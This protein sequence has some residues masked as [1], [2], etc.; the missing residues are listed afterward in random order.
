MDG[1]DVGDRTPVTLHTL[2]SKWLRT[3]FLPLSIALLVC[4][5]SIVPLP[6]YIE[7]PGLAVGISRCV[8]IA[9]RPDAGVDGD[10]LLTTVSQRDA[11]LFGLVLAGLRDDQRVVSKGE[12]LGGTRRDRYL[13]RQ[14]QIFIDATDRAV[15]VALRTA[16]LPVEVRG[17]GVDIVDVIADTP[18]EGVLRPGDVITAVDGRPVTTDTELI[19]AI[20]GTAPLDLRVRRGGD[21]VVEEVAPAVREVEGEQRPMIGVR[22]TTHAPQ[23]RLPFDVDVASGQVGGP[24]AGLMTGLAVYDLVADHDLAEG[25]LIAGTGT[26]ALDGTVGAID[27][28]DLKVVAAARTGVDVF[29]APAPQASEARAALPQ[30]SP[31]TVVGVDTFADARTTLAAGRHD[32]T[33]ERAAAPA[34]CR[35]APDAWGAAPPERADHPEAGVT[36]RRVP[37]DARW[38]PPRRGCA[39]RAWPG[40]STRARWRSCG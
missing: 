33:A 37:S 29:V 10:F 26:L 11:T 22:I 1:T 15:V 12:L 2:I 30:G 32:A 24:S 16:G 5:A 7:Q 20:D 4:A 21:E 31:M 14:R 17:S 39:R 28:I 6:A 18:A 34:S 36:L 3:S 8:A 38:R 25:R 23:V 9:E 35:F 13:E 40:Y 19:E 27:G